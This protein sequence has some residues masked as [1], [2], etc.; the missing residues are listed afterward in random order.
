VGAAPAQTNLCSARV[1]ETVAFY[2][3]LGFAE[4]FRTPTEGSPIQIELVQ[5]RSTQEP[6]GGRRE[7]RRPAR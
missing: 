3:R 1:E 2:A 4:T 7:A 6:R 5:K